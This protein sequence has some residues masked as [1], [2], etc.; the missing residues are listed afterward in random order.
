MKEPLDSDPTGLNRYY[1]VISSPGFVFLSRQ[2]GQRESRRCEDDFRDRFDVA[3]SVAERDDEPQRRAVLRRNWLVVHEPREHHLW[4]QQRPQVLFH[5]EAVRT[6]DPRVMR[7]RL[8]TEHLGE[9]R[10]THAR[11]F[12]DPARIGRA[13]L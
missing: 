11:P 5:P 1:W 6:D 4:L 10:K 13:A 12:D 9:I 8:N 7:E 3:R 2:R